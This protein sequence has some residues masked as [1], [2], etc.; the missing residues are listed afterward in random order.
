MALLIVLMCRVF[1]LRSVPER[2]VAAFGGECLDYI[3][4]S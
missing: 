4:K 1:G 2:N 3:T